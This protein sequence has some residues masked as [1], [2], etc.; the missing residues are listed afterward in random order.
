MTKLAIFFHLGNYSLWPEFKQYL[1]NIFEAGYN[2]D[3]YVSYQEISPILDEI[4][5]LYPQSIFIECKNKLGLDIGG[6][7]LSFDYALRAGKEYDYFLSLHT[8]TDPKWRRELILPICGSASTVREC[9]NVFNQNTNVGIIGARTYVD[10]FTPT[11]NINHSIQQ[12]L[13]QK[14]QLTYKNVMSHQSPLR[15]VAGT[16]FWMRWSII[17]RFAREKKIDFRKEYARLEPGYFKNV[18]HTFTHAWE[19]MFGILTYHYGYHI[20]PM[21]LKKS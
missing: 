12:D 11:N 2:T 8:K 21:D 17:S 16:F 15:F 7:L 6:K 5:Q 1:T 3:L 14:W 4:K 10:R 20:H 19:R 13:C 18:R 9:I